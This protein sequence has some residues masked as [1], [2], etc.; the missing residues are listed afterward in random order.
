[1]KILTVSDS[2]YLH[3][4]LARVHREMIRALIEDGHDVYV[5]G[6]GWN[7]KA[8]PGDE[9]NNIWWYED[10]K[11]GKKIRSFP[12]YKDPKK[13]IV[14]IYEII[15]S[16]N[17][18]DALFTIGDYHNFIG[19]DQLKTK[20][21]FNH[22]WIAYYTI[23]SEPIN[24]KYYSPMNYIDKIIVPSRFG[25]NVLS[26]VNFESEYIPYGV[27]S[28]FYK[29]NDDKIYIERQS[30]NIHNKFRFIN[31]SRNCSRK[32]IPAFLSSLKRVYNINPNISAYLHTSVDEEIKNLISRFGLEY[33]VDLP[34]EKVSLEIGCSDKELNFQ[35][36]L[37]D[38]VIVTSTSEGFCLPLLE[39]QKC[40][41]TPIATNYSSMIELVDYRNDLPPNGELVN[42]VPFY[43]TLQHKIAIIDEQD[44]CSKML[45]VSMNKN[46][47]PKSKNIKFAEKFTWDHTKKSIKE[48]F[49]NISHS[50]SLPVE[51]I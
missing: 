41:L 25:Q 18:V 42:Y 16:L 22:K 36:N 37:S 33:I 44:L 23:D 20:S 48:I 28:N 32:N 47:Y 19:F 27:D 12:I 8:Y 24:E 15:N 49:N 31:V 45:K 6:W 1:M 34:E 51:K 17:G 10:S 21:G 13:L 11:T 9:E 39:G 5:A 26:D 4:G 43:S 50:I 46:I 2:P 29:I 7:I 35:Y 14:M 30:R 38:S 40:G 3:S